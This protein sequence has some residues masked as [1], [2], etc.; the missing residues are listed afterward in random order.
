MI[1]LDLLL[2]TEGDPRAAPTFAY[3]GETWTLPVSPPIETL[4]L[5]TDADVVLLLIEEGAPGQLERLLALRPRPD[6]RA[7]RVLAAHLGD[8]Y[9][10]T[11]GESSASAVSSES[12]GE[13]SRPTSSASTD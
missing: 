9:G 12:T 8:L 10:V 11:L 4:K 7:L 2:E 1:D 13:Q 6:V 3:R 5:T